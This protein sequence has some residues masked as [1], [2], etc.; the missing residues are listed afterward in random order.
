MVWIDGTEK[1]PQKMLEEYV[2]SFDLTPQGIIDELDSMNIDYN[3]VSA[4][5]HFGKPGLPWED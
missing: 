2:Y 5:W 4:Y 3:Q 1:E